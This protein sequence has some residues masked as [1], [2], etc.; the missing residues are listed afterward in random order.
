MKTSV[1]GLPADTGSFLALRGSN[2]A[3]RRGLDLKGCAPLLRA[4]RSEFQ[5]PTLA[6]ALYPN[7]ALVVPFQFAIGDLVTFAIGPE[8]ATG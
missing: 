8:P 5:F 3:W 2:A 1:V 4:R 7:G 6:A